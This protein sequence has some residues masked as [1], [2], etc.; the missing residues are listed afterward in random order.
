VFFLSGVARLAQCFGLGCNFLILIG[1]RKHNL[2]QGFALSQFSVA[3]GL[4]PDLTAEHF[5]NIKSDILS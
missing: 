5:L 4:L 2:V 1:T 3:V